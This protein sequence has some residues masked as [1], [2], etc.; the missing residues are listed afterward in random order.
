GEQFIHLL[1][2]K[3][4]PDLAGNLRKRNV[5]SALFAQ[6]RQEGV[7]VIGLDVLGIDLNRRPQARLDL[8]EH[9]QV[10]GNVSLELRLVQSIAMQFGLPRARFG[11]GVLL[12]DIL[13]TLL[14]FVGARSGRVGALGLFAQQF[15]INEAV[16]PA[17]AVLVGN[18]IQR[19]TFHEYF[20]T[21]S[22]VPI[23]LQND[24]AVDGRDNAVNHVGGASGS[25]DC[26]Q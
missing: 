21:H 26:K 20:E 25:G 10:V 1:F 22:M 13:D 18:L 12:L 23:A 17:A 4:L 15:L 9:G 16:E 7:A 5:L 14:H 2:G 19:T 8:M 11:G 3:N 6:L 24:M